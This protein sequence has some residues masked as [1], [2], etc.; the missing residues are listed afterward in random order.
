MKTL[1]ATNG[2]TVKNLT[3]S[4][5]RLAKSE[6]AQ[7]FGEGEE[8]SI[9][10]RDTGTRLYHRRANGY[11]FRTLKR[12]KKTKKKPPIIKL[13]VKHG[14]GGYYANSCGVRREIGKQSLPRAKEEAEKAF[15]KSQRVV[16]YD[17][18]SDEPVLYRPAGGG[19]WQKPNW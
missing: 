18:L 19:N 14:K 4:N 10:D 6:A 15:F 13:P 3:N 12:S 9:C 17:K 16:I 7:L 8:V 1:I 5:H 11:S 2:K